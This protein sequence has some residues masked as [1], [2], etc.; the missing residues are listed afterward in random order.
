[1]VFLAVEFAFLCLLALRRVV[2]MF[3]GRSLILTLLIRIRLRM[4]L[5]S[6]TI[7]ELIAISELENW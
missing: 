4:G 5:S 7:L 6:R 1:M 2:F 3:P